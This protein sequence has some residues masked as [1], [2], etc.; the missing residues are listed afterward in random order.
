MCRTIKKFHYD[1]GRNCIIFQTRSEQKLTISSN[2][3]SSD[4]ERSVFIVDEDERNYTVTTFDGFQFEFSKEMVEIND[5]VI[6]RDNKI[7][8]TKAIYENWCVKKDKIA[9]SIRRRFIDG[10]DIFL[11]E[12]E[13]TL[14]KAEYFLIRVPGLFCIN[15]RK[16]TIGEWVENFDIFTGKI[17]TT[18]N[19][20]HQVYT[21]C[22]VLNIGVN[23]LSGSHTATGWCLDEQKI[24]RG[25]TNHIGKIREYAYKNKQQRYLPLQSDKTHALM[26]LNELGI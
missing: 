15:D 11:R 3:I 25:T 12:K 26:L 6:V 20:K 16:F 13:L 23:I 1:E 2:L 17:L 8:L 5:A 22:A 9:G 7:Y 14:Q 10:M 18:V 24:V 21:N 4:K 19:Q